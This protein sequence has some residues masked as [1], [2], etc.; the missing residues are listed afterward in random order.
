MT[1]PVATLTRRS[2]LAGA[3]VAALPLGAE[4][5]LADRA[6]CFLVVGD[7]GDP[8]H[9]SQAFN[10]A[11]QMGV[12]AEQLPARFVISTGDNFYAK[13]VESVSDPKWRSAFEAVYSSPSLKCPWYPVLGN[14]DHQGNDQAEI[15]YS[16]Q[17]RRWRMPSRYYSHSE[18]LADGSSAKFFLLDTDPIARLNWADRWLWPDAVVQQQIDWLEE[19]LAD[20]RDRWKIVVGHHPIFSGGRHGDTPQM[21][22]LVKPLLDRHGVKA[23]INGHDHDLQHVVVEDVHYLTSGA[24]SSARTT[25]PRE[26]TLYADSIL[27]FLRVRL[28]PTEMSLEFINETGQI[29]HSS[30]IAA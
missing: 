30:T 28:L 12:S 1:S 22:E 19:G 20:S 9:R 4:A 5:A 13:G 10:V 6:L 8:K 7:W 29:A 17:S 23:Y 18:T 27:G 25:G 3:A 21:I 11:A 14:H 16:G 2:F 24:G 26:G 15:S